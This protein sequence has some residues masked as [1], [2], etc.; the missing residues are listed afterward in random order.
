MS[1]PNVR[2]HSTTV[3]ALPLL[4]LFCAAGATSARAQLSAFGISEARTIDGSGNNVAHADWG[5]ANIELMRLAACAYEDG[6]GLPAGATRPSARVISNAVVA[7]TGSILNSQHASDFVWQWGQFVDHDLDL[8][9]AAAPQEQFNIAVPMGDPYFDPLLTG[10]QTIALDRSH[11]V[12][13]GVPLLRQQMNEITS[14]MDASNVYGSDSARALE[15][16]TLDGTGRL[17]TSAGALLPFN[18]H[19]FPNAPTAADPT[20]FLAG[21]VRCNEQVGLTTMH[22]LFVREHNYWAVR[23]HNVLPGASDEDL[24][25]LAR[26]MVVAEIQRITYEEFLPALFG[27]ANGLAPYGGYQPGVRPSVCTEFSTASYRFGHSMLSPTLQRL[28]ANGQ[29]IPD[30]NL[31]LLASFFSPGQIIDHGG[32]EPLLRGLAH[33]QAQEVDTMIVD[34][35]RNFL[36]GPPG[37]G[38]FDLASLNIQRGRDH[39]LPSYNAMRVAYG[40]S[41]KSSFTQVS[42]DPAVQARLAGVYASV[43]DIDAWVGGLAED[44]LPG[45]LVGELVRTVLKDQFERVRDGDRFWYQVYLPAPLLA[46]VNTQKLSS[47]IER[48]TRIRGLDADVF[49]VH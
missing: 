10:I 16:R 21:D 32:I 43:D 2:S 38:G 44:H 15:L 22:T 7:Q 30:G 14:F 31:P 34:D 27:A 33:Q 11:Y 41:A 3:P 1:G 45:A 20:L 4:V 42:S 26:V 13:S 48:N 46:F 25:Q 18:V 6:I 29:V 19:A 8:T 24:Y 49:H 12:M 17:K 28:D 23:F 9:S 37:S 40:L 39:G 47:V 35:V 5:A 36:F